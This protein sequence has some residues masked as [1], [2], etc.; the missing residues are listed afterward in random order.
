MNGSRTIGGGQNTSYSLFGLS[1]GVSLQS[2]TRYQYELLFNTQF[3][4]PSGVMSYA[5]STSTGIAQHNYTAQSN[6]TT[7]IDGYTAGITMM[8][9]NATGTNIVAQNGIGDLANGFQHTIIYGTIDVTTGTNVNFMVSQD[10][11]GSPVWTVFAGSYVK[12]IAI[13]PIG[14]NSATGNWS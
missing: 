11:G 2:N 9:Y 12:L 4:K 10:Q 6:K 3:N 7:T 5:L 1:N 13:G 8:S 14:A